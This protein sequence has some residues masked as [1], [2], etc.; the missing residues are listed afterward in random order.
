MHNK[1]TDPNAVTVVRAL[2]E[3]DARIHSP[4]SAAEIAEEYAARNAYLERKLAELEKMVRA[5]RKAEAAA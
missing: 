2:P 4:K 5:G 3:I 1:N